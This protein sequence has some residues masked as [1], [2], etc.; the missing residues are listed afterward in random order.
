MADFETKLQRL[1]ERGNPVGAEEL[2]ERIEADLAGDPLVVVAKRR[3]GKPMTKT[4]QSPRTSQPNR[5]RGPAWV[6][7][8]FAA[9]LAVT[10]LYLAPADDGQEVADTQPTPTTVAPDVEPMK[11][12]EVIEAGVAA[13]YSGEGE[14]AA[15]FFELADRDDEQIRQEA[16]YQAAIGG[17][18]TLNCRGGTDGVFTCNTPY[19]NAMT[20]AIEHLDLPGDRIRVVVEDGEITE[21]AFPEHTFMVAEMGTFLAME[22]RFEGYELCIFGPFPE[23]CAMIQMENLDGWV[24]W[25]ETFEPTRLAEF[26]LESWYS[27]D[28]L[29]ARHVSDLEAAA[30]ARSSEPNETIEYE[31]ILGAEVSLDGCEEVAANDLA[32]PNLV[33]LS[34]QVSYANAMNAA[35]GKPAS[36]TLKHFDIWGPIFV[37]HRG[38]DTGWYEIDYPEDT[39]LRQSFRLF[40]ESGELRDDY[41][42]AGCASARTPECANLIMANLDD[43]AVWYETN[44]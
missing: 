6:V 21:F 3:E 34:C 19:Q 11:D 44:K 33:G 25:R 23:S 28:C 7:A 42:A 32:N 5:N 36:T 4:Q 22:G 2:I 9:V 8:A 38:N 30:C 13:L 1:S 16:A 40:A 26:A 14:R 10:T 15:E 20:D 41:V 31:S 24:E 43:W 12:L 27:G 35:V 29:G 37:S 18:L 17:R 39:D